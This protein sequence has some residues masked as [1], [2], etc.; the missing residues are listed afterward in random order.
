MRN[1]SSF[2]AQDM[3]RIA[4]KYYSWESFVK[5]FKEDLRKL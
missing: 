3:R 5:A 2:K 4:Y 1:L